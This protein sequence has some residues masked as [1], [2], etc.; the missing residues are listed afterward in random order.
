MTSSSL[1]SHN[2]PFFSKLTSNIL[3]WIASNFSSSIFNSKSH[4]L[5]LII[6]WT[7]FC[8]FQKIYL[9]NSLRYDSYQTLDSTSLQPQGGTCQN[10]DRDARPIFLGLKF[11]QILFFWVSQNFRYFFW[12]WQISSYFLGLPIL[13]SHTWILWMKNTQY[14]KKII[15]TF[16]IYSNFDNNCILSHSIF[17]GLNFGAFYFLGFE[18][19]V[20][21]F[22]LGSWNLFSDEHPYQRNA[23]VP[24]P[25]P[26]P[27]LQSKELW[28]HCS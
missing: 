8:G 14:W 20:I 12:V 9:S 19:R 6:F 16:H 1:F 2:L 5:K 15:V 13:V 28:S 24:P 21:L 4:P 26:P 22:F 3:L 10:F 11:F 17:R 25:P 18:F 7:S 27:S 23:C